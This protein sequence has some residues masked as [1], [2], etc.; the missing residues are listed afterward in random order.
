MLNYQF[1]PDGILMLNP[2][3]PFEAADFVAL[4]S[5]VDAYLKQH[6]VLHGVLIRAKSFPGW[7]D[8]DA[9]ISH[10]KFLKEHLKKIEKIAVVADGTFANVIP[11]IANYVV[12]AQVQHFDLTRESDAVAWL[13]ETADTAKQA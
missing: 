13:E 2:S 6:G 9:M 7:K 4:T 3:E 10:L 1:L 12:H 5:D 11:K 8:L